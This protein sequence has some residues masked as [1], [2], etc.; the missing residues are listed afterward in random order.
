MKSIAAI[1]AFCSLLTL[2]GCATTQD[3]TPAQEAFLAAAMATPLTFTMPTS[4]V[5]EAWA[6]AQSFVTR[7]SPMQIQPLTP[8]VIRTQNPTSATS[9]F[10]YYVR[11]IP[12]GGET[13]FTV[14]CLCAGMNPSQ[15]SI[16][17]AHILA[18]YM[19]T[20]NLDPSLVSR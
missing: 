14:E 2:F 10:G 16:R 18:Y 6:R 12:K 1:A 5:D 4:Q 7:F 13:Q 11:K 9:A 20:G 19:K 15:P 17:N 3:L 8:H